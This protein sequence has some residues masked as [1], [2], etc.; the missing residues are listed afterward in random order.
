MLVRNAFTHDTRVEKE[1][2]SLARAGFQVTVVADGGLGLPATES[3]DGYE[4]RPVALAERRIPLVRFFRR[5]HRLQ[6]TL[7]ATDPEILHA[8]DAA[9]ALSPV[10]R[11]AARIGVPF[12]YDSHELWTGRPPHS[13]RAAC[14]FLANAYY[15]RVERRYVPRAAGRITVSA[16]I[17]RHLVGPTG[18]PFELVPNYPDLPEPPDLVVRSLRSLPGGE[19]IP[20][21]SPIVLYVGGVNAGRGLEPLVRAMARVRQDAHLVMLGDGPLAG[22]LA[23]IAENRKK[24]WTVATTS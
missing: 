21:D 17:A 19:A 3:R 15:R 8:H 5:N 2:R 9:N 13:R 12:V 20:P 10:G 11:V 22:E 1:A 23:C 18:A 7:A 6:N 24:D 4:V 16:P 14:R